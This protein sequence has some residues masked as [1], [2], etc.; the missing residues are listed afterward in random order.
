MNCTMKRKCFLW[1]C[2]QYNNGIWLPWSGNCT[3]HGIMCSRYIWQRNWIAK[4]VFCFVLLLRMLHLA[5]MAPYDLTKVLTKINPQNR[6][7]TWIFLT[8]MLRDYVWL[9][10]EINT[11]AKDTLVSMIPEHLLL[12]CWFQCR[13]YE[14]CYNKCSPNSLQLAEK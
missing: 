1:Y 2:W 6:S 14:M 12:Q 5:L 11:A 3:E 13:F 4:I 10:T 9:A 7:F 8:K